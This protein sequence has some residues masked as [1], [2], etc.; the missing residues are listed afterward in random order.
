MKR[1]LK[2]TLTV[3]FCLLLVN[4]VFAQTPAIYLEIETV[5]DYT[6][7]Y[8]G[9]NTVDSLDASTGLYVSIYGKN[10]SDFGGH[11]LRF[12]YDSSLIDVVGTNSVFKVEENGSV[13]DAN[14]LALLDTTVTFL[15]LPYDIRTYIGDVK[16]VM[17]TAG[18][19]GANAVANAVDIGS[20]FTLLARIEMQTAATF[21]TTDSTTVILNFADI[22]VLNTGQT[23][24][25]YVSVT[26]V[27][28]CAINGASIPDYELPIELSTFSA[29]SISSD[30]VQLD[31]STASETNNLRFDILR[32]ADKD[33]F[34]VIASVQGHGTTLEPQTYQ[35][36]DNTVTSGTYYYRLKQVDI[37]G[38]FEI[39]DRSIEVDVP[40]P[41]EYELG[42]NYPNPFNPS[43]TIPFSL[44]ES[45]KVKVTVY[46][47]LGQ[48]MRVLTNK[49][50]HAGIHKI[51]FNAAGMTTGVYFYR[52]EVNGVAFM[53]KFVLVK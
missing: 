13:V 43:T 15:P 19:G 8:D 25:E 50:Y 46:N 35:F 36:V 34:E 30:K 18:I 10:I 26:G 33:N 39:F 7:G 51:K 14:P 47:I 12:I 24:Y 32:S 53:K 48:E 4:G 49:N 52:L 29:V 3:V 31:W 20:T 27:T 41:A 1:I 11:E 6:P 22:V 45:G 17:L 28:N 2:L 23:A 9:I 37:D 16:Q 5:A 40:Y 38:S 42:N 44:K 21:A